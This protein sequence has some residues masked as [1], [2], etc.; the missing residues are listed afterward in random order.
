[1]SPIVADGSHTWHEWRNVRLRRKLRA[2]AE[3][4][5]PGRQ[6]SLGWTVRRSVF[7]AELL[8]IKIEDDGE[9]PADLTA[10]LGVGRCAP[11]QPAKSTEVRD[12]ELKR[13]GLALSVVEVDPDR[14]HALVLADMTDDSSAEGL[15]ADRCTINQP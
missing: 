13:Q 6:R 10:D 11:P 15:M 3:L 14:G 8:R 7:V 9:P 4:A 2:C 1:M 12:P 5:F